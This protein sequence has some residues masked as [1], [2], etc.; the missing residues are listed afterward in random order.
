MTLKIYPVVL[1]LVR[2]L[3]P[4]LLAVRRRSPALGDQMERALISV[5]LNVAEGAYSRGKNREARYHSALGSARE[6]LACWETAEAFGWVDPLEP[7]IAALF[8]R[9]I[10]DVGPT[11]GALSA[12]PRGR[13]KLSAVRAAVGR[14]R[15][16]PAANHQP[17]VDVGRIF[18]PQHATDVGKQLRVKSQSE[19]RDP[20]L[21]RR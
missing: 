9:V 2:R 4:L 12:C 16:G 8:W 14:V 15:F 5:P 20:L 10:G 18:G 21:K 7:D 11:L 19:V 6:A 17:I 1:E 13:R 3:A